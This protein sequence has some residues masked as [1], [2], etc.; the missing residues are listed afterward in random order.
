M[1]QNSREI[2]HPLGLIIQT[3]L[4][5]PSFSSKG[6]ETTGKNSELQYYLNLST[7]FITESLLISAYDYKY[8]FIPSRK[9]LSFASL[10]FIDSGGYEVSTFRDFSEIKK[11]PVKSK[12]WN[13]NLHNETI[14][15]WSNED[16][17]IIIS[18]DSDKSRKN[19]SDQ[20]N[21]AKELFNRHP[22]HMSDFLIKPETKDEQTI[23]FDK[24]IRHIKKL[25]DFNI[26]GLTEKEAGDSM[27]LRMKNILKLRN[28]LDEAKIESP[29]HIFGCLDP[30]SC[31]LYYTSGAEI[32]DGLTW[33]RYSYYK[34]IAIYTRNFNILNEELGIN[35]RNEQV[36]ASSI[37]RNIYFL[38]RFKYKMID[39]FKMKDFS[40]FKDIT[41]EEVITVLENAYNRFNREV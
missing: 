27:I 28:A 16:N 8:K 11:M 31:V 25:K 18:Y 12:K 30:I 10:I 36:L 29:I 15:E 39:F 22:N 3:P 9:K 23:N 37:T 20:I 7:P 40:V 26:I 17:V 1:K 2:K 6:F 33:L 5:V 34:S 4:L 13:E 21:S 14:N 32:F 38:Y 24:L 41:N 35:T 19:F